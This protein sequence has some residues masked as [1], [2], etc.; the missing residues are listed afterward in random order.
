MSRLV[1]VDPISSG[2]DY[3]PKALSR[4]MDVLVVL[5]PGLPPVFASQAA[6]LRASHPGVEFLDFPSGTP[7]RDF[8]SRFVPGDWDY[9]VCAGETG[10]AAADHIRRLLDATPR[11]AEPDEPR[12]D[13]FSAQQALERAGLRHIRSWCL[14]DRA[15]VDEL[16]GGP[17]PLVVKPTA[18]AG[19]DGVRV[20]DSDEQL[21]AAVEESLGN[22]NALGRSNE[23][24]V[25]QEYVQ[26]VEY[27][28]DGCAYGDAW[29]AAAV[30]RYEKDLVNGVPVYRS[31]AW[32]DRDA[33]PDADRLEAYVSAILP[34]LGVHVG[35]FHAEFF[36]TADDWVMI[37]IGLRPHGGGH[38]RFTELVTGT[39]QIELELDCVAA[40]GLASG[41]M[42]PLLRR[43]GVAF[44]SVDRPVVFHADPG[45]ALAAVAGLAHSSISVRAGESADPPRTLLD[46]FGLGFVVLLAETEQQ[47]ADRAEL[48]RAAFAGCHS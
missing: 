23:R 22:V 25:V 11:N 27:V 14:S 44:F 17:F 19:T 15:G 45:E 47:L 42:P 43:G 16:R 1:V 10:T 24:L 20:V 41:A 8:D 38:P 31:L 4:G 7:D 2:V 40:G 13:K 5:T 29:R 46:T 32:L 12:L 36:R 37:E 30:C 9:V 35:C 21:A 48:A 33:I 34:A 6:A 39:S 26:G 3:V 18:S 28:V